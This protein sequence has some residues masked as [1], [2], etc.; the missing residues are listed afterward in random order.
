MINTIIDYD[1]LYCIFSLSK[2]NKLYDT[3]L[4]L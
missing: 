2:L 1:L 3:Y 4:I